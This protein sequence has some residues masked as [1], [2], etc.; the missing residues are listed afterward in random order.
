[1]YYS[2]DFN[3]YLVGP[4]FS[5]RPVSWDSFLTLRELPTDRF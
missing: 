5:I 2:Y 1:M 4:R 3:E